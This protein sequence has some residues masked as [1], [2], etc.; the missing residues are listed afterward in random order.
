MHVNGIDVHSMSVAEVVERHTMLNEKDGEKEKMKERVES[1][2]KNLTPDDMA[3]PIHNSQPLLHCV[4][5]NQPLWPSY[6][7]C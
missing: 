3:W 4:Y 5:G 2:G 7:L 1:Y 6:I